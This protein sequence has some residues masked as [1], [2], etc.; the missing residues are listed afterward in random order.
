VSGKDS[1]QN[2]EKLLE[3]LFSLLFWRNGR[4]EISIEEVIDDQEE[5]VEEQ[6]SR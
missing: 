1:F 3:R 5:K 6:E 4:I 2:L